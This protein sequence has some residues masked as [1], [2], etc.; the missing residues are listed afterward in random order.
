MNKRARAIQTRRVELGR[1]EVPA[2]ALD[3]LACAED[4]FREHA[5]V[6]QIETLMK[7]VFGSGAEIGPAYALRAHLAVRQGKLRQA[8][9]DATKAVKL[10]PEDPSGF[11]VRGKI[12]LERG[13][14]SALADLQKAATL[15]RNRDAETLAALADALSGAGRIDEA[16]KTAR[17]A[18]ALRPADKD[19]AEQVRDLEG[20]SKKRAG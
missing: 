17:A 5:L 2:S 9:D 15:T 10:S 16:L 12:E 6:S 18:L 1:L 13:Q 4:L 7:T 19:I 14:P 11:L 20:R 8:L 3:A